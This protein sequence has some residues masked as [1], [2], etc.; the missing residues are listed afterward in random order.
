[1]PTHGNSASACNAYNSGHAHVG[2]HRAV[3]TAMIR[4]KIEEMLRNGRRVLLFIISG[5][6]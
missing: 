2:D 5:Q 6:G 1:M 4:R 3:S